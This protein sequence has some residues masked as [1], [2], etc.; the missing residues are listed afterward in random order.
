MSAE[1]RWASELFP[2]HSKHSGAVAVLKAADEISARCAPDPRRDDAIF[3]ELDAID[4]Q[5]R[6]PWSEQ[7]PLELGGGTHG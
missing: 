6:K 5:D 7:Q 2:Q 3:R 4:E 1:S